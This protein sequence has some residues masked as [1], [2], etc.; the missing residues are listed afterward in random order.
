MLEKQQI[1]LTIESGAGATVA[2]NTQENNTQT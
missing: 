1:E 2:L